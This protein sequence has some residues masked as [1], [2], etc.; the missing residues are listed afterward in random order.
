MSFGVADKADD[1]KK[2]LNAVCQILWLEIQDCLS[3]GEHNWQLI[4]ASQKK[5]HVMQFFFLIFCCW[6]IVLAGVICPAPFIRNLGV[7]RSLSHDVRVSASVSQ[8][9]ENTPL[10][11]PVSCA[12]NVRDGAKAQFSTT[13][14][15]FDRNFETKGLLNH[16][17]V[18]KFLCSTFQSTTV[19]ASQT[20]ELFSD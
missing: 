17:A 7:L 10:I 16:T 5:C 11:N 14:S 1:L 3:M 18:S 12:A 19:D 4:S 20:E 8:V 9:R 15:I 6:D 13:T 2:I